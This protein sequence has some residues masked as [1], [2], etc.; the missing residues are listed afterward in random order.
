[1][2]LLAFRVFLI[3]LF[4][5]LVGTAILTKLSIDRQAEQY[6]RDAIVGA[7]RIG[8][9]IK[10]S[11]NYSMMLNRQE[12]IHQIISTIGNEPGLEAIRIYDKKGEIRLSTVAGE[13]G[14]YV[15]MNAEACN[16]CHSAGKTPLSPHP[17]ELSRIFSSRSDQK[18]LD[19]FDRRLPCSCTV[20]DHSWSTRHYDAATGN[21]FTP[22][23]F[24][25]LS[26]CECPLHVFRDDNIRRHFYLDRR[27]HSCPQI[28]SWH[29]RNY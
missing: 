26:I 14:T 29:T 3:I 10:R 28:D 15:N 6:L 2:N 24:E 21:R 19:M 9:V 23:E 18:R 17:R 27:E 11:T 16:A 25:P 1:L 20:A 8:D 22:G 7:N 13:V 12:D 5:M 4:V